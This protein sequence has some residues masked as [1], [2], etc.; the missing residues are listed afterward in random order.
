[1]MRAGFSVLLVVIIHDHVNAKLPPGVQTCSR[2]DPNLNE[3]FKDKMNIITPLL[4]DGVPSMGL[5]PFDPLHADEAIIDDTGTRRQVAINLMMRNISYIGFRDG[6][7]TSANVDLVNGEISW[8]N[9]VPR[10]Q[11]TGQYEISGRI[12]ILPFTGKGNFNITLQNVDTMFGFRIKN[13]TRNG[14]VYIVPFDSENTFLPARAHL[15]LSGLFNGDKRLGDHMN[16]FLNEN[17]RELMADMGPPLSQVIEALS[18]S[19]AGKLFS[20]SPY[21]TIFP[22]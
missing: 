2:N 16:E 1:M 20:L 22:V 3:C 14:K 5:F 11:I 12:L 9:L 10:L 18:L 19:Y 15:F 17:W 8:K 6:N 21:D 13:E 4:A 7:I